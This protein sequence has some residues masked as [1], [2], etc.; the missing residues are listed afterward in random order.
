MEVIGDSN[1]PVM[2]SGDY[3]LVNTNDTV[4]SPPGFFALF[5][6]FGNVIKQVEHIAN[7]DPVRFVIKSRNPEYQ[8]YER[9][10]DEVRIIGRVESIVWRRL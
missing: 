9:D 3:V 4:P 2:H 10:A 7:S 1:E 8:A 5:D 6:G